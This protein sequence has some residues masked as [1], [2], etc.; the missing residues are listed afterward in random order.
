M[1]RIY[2][3]HENIDSLQIQNFF[4]ARAKKETDAVN[5]VMLQSAGS[6]LAT[7]RDIHER[8]HLLPRPASRSK[9]LE[10]GCGAGRLALAYRD[11]GH[12]YLGIDFS[13]ELIARANADVAIPDRIHFQVGQVPSIEVE[14]L[15]LQPPF[16]LII[17]TALLLYLNDEAVLQTFELIGKLAAPVAEVYVREPLSDIAKRMTLKQHFSEEL[18]DVY[19]AIYRT[20][21]EMKAVLDQTLVSGGFTYKVCGDYA[22]PPSLQNRAE[23]AQRYFSLSR[24]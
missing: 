9:I 10:L 1:A 13:D 12:A 7:D 21:D 15:R 14:D 4:N 2:D 6:S 8:S 17:V 3:T 19:N 20:P 11:D 5:A 18:D 22:F 23:T 24:G 16:D